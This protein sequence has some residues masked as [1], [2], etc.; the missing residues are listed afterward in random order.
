VFMLGRLRKIVKSTHGFLTVFSKTLSMEINE[1][2]MGKVGLNRDPL[3]YPH[4]LIRFVNQ[5]H[6]RIEILIRALQLKAAPTCDIINRHLVIKK[7][8]L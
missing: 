4:H 8:C 6:A 2:Y 7:D 5:T 1:L 3:F